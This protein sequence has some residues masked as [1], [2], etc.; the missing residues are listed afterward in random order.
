LFSPQVLRANSQAP[1]ERR[2]FLLEGPPL[3]VLL[4]GRLFLHAGWRLLH[5][6]LSGNFRPR[7]QPYRSLLWRSEGA[8]VQT[9]GGVTRLLVDDWSLHFLEEALLLYQ[10]DSP[11]LNPEQAPSVLREACALLD[12]ELLRLTVEQAGCSETFLATEG[13]GT[14]DAWPVKG[15]SLET[16]TA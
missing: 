15:D 11:A 13:S 12:F 9:R 8:S 16:G 7:Q 10:E 6:P 14:M 3:E 1:E 5:H 2:C 4:A